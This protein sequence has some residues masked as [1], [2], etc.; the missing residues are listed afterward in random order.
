MDAISG[1]MA[2]LLR[3]IDIN[4][5]G[6]R[7]KKGQGILHLIMVTR[8]SHEPQQGNQMLKCSCKSFINLK[9]RGF[10]ELGEGGGPGRRGGGEGGGRGVRT[11]GERRRKGG[12][13]GRR[14]RS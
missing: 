11:G 1:L 12:G 2:D 14:R 3:L 4:A 5:G 7:L 9:R 6:L 13:G 8:S 10:G